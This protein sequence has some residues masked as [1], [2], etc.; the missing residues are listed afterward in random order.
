MA[1]RSTAL[2]RYTDSPSPSHESAETDACGV[3]I[4]RARDSLWKP[5]PTMRVNEERAFFFF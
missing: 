2:T 1:Y 5:L 3:E 4:Y